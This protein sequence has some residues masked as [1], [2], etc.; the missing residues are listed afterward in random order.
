[1]I[2]SFEDVTCNVYQYSVQSLDSSIK[3]RQFSKT[4]LKYNNY[5]LSFTFLT[6]RNKRLRNSACC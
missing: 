3:S 1:M 5:L 2:M 6:K 4:F